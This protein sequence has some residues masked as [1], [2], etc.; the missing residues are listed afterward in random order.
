MSDFELRRLCLEHKV[1]VPSFY[2]YF[3]AD[4]ITNSIIIFQLFYGSPTVFSQSNGLL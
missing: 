1:S 3:Y 4:L 2:F